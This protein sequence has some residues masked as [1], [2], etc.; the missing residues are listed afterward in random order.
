MSAPYVVET[1][2]LTKRN[3]HL[4]GHHVF[5][6]AGNLKLDRFQAHCA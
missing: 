4:S 6:S 5:D 3:F 2:G 1:S